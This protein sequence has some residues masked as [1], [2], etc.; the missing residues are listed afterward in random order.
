MFKD[1]NRLALCEVTSNLD[2]ILDRFC[3]GV[4]EYRLLRE[5]SWCVFIEPFADFNVIL[6]RSGGEVRMSKFLNLLDHA[7]N[8][9]W[10]AIANIGYANTCTKID[11]L[12]SI[13]IQDNRIMC[14]LDNDRDR[15]TE[16]TRSRLCTAL[17][18]LS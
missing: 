14:L 11:D 4:H 8:D 15:H 7:S 17:K 12:I 5:S 13:D 3:A 16:S 1:N 18:H 10:C 2:C 9:A 6:V